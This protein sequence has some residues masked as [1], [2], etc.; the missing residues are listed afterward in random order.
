MPVGE[1]ELTAKQKLQL[2]WWMVFGKTG[3][4]MFKDQLLQGKQ[5]GKDGL[6][7]MLRAFPEASAWPQGSSEEKLLRLKRPMNVR[8]RC[9]LLR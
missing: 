9:L 7:I 3:K 6:H 8:C 1:R 5:Q 4:F 2:S